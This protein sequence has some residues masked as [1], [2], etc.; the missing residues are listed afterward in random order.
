MRT[1]A[2]TS[3]R[4]RRSLLATLLTALLLAAPGTV[5]SQTNPPPQTLPNL[6]DL[7]RQLKQYHDSGAY[8]RDVAA[9]LSEAQ[10]YVERRAKEVQKPALVLDI[11]ETS[12]SN[13]PEIA[14]NDFGFIANGPCDLPGGPCGNR[15]WD[16]SGQAK[17]IQ[18]TLALFLAAKAAGVTVLFITGRDESGRAATETN[19]VNIG[20]IGWAALAMRPAGSTTPSAAD[21]KTPERAKIEAR[22]YTIIA[23]VGDQPSDLAGGHAERTFQVPNPFYRIP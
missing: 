2:T 1:P 22:G 16:A 10:Q 6:G 23:N 20:Y 17:A 13:W 9:V 18:P 12:L 7:K 4:L 8:D 21:Y 19:L 14:A 5:L 11:D 15:S 3:H